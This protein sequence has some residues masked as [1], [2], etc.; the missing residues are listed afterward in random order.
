MARHNTG[1]TGWNG[2]AVVGAFFA[3]LIILGTLLT[4]TGIS[5]YLFAAGCAGIAL[6]L[7]AMGAMKFRID[8]IRSIREFVAA[9]ATLLAGLV[10]VSS[11]R[12]TLLL[13]GIAVLCLIYATLELALR[14][15]ER[16]TNNLSR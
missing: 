9:S 7:A 5:D 16:H 1:R 2:G 3:A 12:R 10:F 8:K 15:K 14:R 4:G 13:A 11:E 6:V